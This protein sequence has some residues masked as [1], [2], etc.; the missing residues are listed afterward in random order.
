MPANPIVWFEI[1]VA[2]M[3][4]ARAFYE[5]LLQVKLQA[6]DMPD[7][8]MWSF[9][10]QQDA[11]GAGGALIRMEG[12]TPGMGGTLVYFN[13]DDCGVEA[14]RAAA[15]G[16]AIFKDKTSIGPHGFFALVNDTEGNLVG[17]YSM[18]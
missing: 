17:L 3:A 15:S 13:C 14:K 9:P 7:A 18:R 5:S 8:E 4:R 10:M 2:D 12:V 1:Y 11:P 16:G 6:M